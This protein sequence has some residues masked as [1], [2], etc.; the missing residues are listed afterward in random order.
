MQILRRMKK[1]Q[2]YKMRRKKV[3]FISYP[4]SIDLNTSED[5]PQN[6]QTQNDDESYPT[7]LSFAGKI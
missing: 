1:V 7:Y 6:Q 5:L 2:G 4:C 3:K